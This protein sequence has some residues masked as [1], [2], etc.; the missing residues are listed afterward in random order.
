M[1]KREYI[2]VGHVI[3]ITLMFAVAKG[4]HDIRM[5]YNGT[6]SGL[7]DALWA[8]H[9][10]LP[11]LD[12]TLRSLLPGYHQADL[13]VAEMF[14]CFNL[15]PD[16]RPYAGVDVTH[17][18]NHPK[19]REDWEQHRKRIWEC[20]WR[21]F[22]GMRDSP[23][24]SIQLMLVAK[25]LAY[26]DRLDSNNPFQWDRIELNLPGSETYDPSLPWVMKIRRDGKLGCEI[27]I[28]VDDGRV[29]GWCKL[30]CWRAVQKFSRVLTT[31]GIQDASRKRTSPST[32]PG[33]WAGGVTSTEYGKDDG[34]PRGD[35]VK[36]V[37]QIKWEKI[38]SLVRELREM[39]TQDSKK[40]NRKRLEQIRGFLV[41]VARTFK[42]M[43]PYIKGLHLTIDGWREDRD[44]EGYRVRSNVAEIRQ[45]EKD[46]EQGI[47]VDLGVFILEE[48]TGDKE[49]PEEV[50]AVPRLEHDIET[51][52]EFTRGEAPAVEKVRVR[53]ALLALYLMGD[54][55][56]DGFGSSWWDGERLEYEAGTWKRQYGKLSSNF[57]EA[58]NLTA[59]AEEMGNR[60]LLS[61]REIFIFTDNSTYEGTFYKGHSKTS[62]AL[63]DLVRRL[64]MLE[65]K[66]GAIIHV[67]HIAGTRMKS[68][69]VDGL[70]RGDLVEGIMKGSNPWAAIPIN[71]DANF[72]TN[73]R[74]ETWIRS[75]WNDKYQTPWF[76]KKGD[77]STHY[78]SE[79]LK[80]LEPTDWFNLFNIKEHRLWIPPPAAMETV[81]EIFNEDRLVYPH[82]THVFAIPR[83]M[84]HLWRKQLFKDA[85]L[86]FYVRPG[87]P[88]WPRSMHEP[89]T[90][91][92][93]FPIA[94]VHNYRGPW[95]VKQLPGSKEFGE[96]LDSEFGDPRQ[97]GREEFLD[98]GS[99][100]PSL[101]ED[102]HRWTRD[103]LFEFLR[104]QR[105]FPPVQSGLLRC[106][107]PALRGG[108]V[109]NSKIVGRRRGRQRVRDRG[110]GNRSLHVR[111][112]GR[113]SNE[114]SF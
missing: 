58:C 71:E 49:A 74:V 109:P 83:L 77:R 69:G 33:P 79:E 114:S 8:P 34:N 85:D 44:E 96:R 100:M 31:L 97:V 55:S 104:Q 64:R 32:T 46:L 93:V 10:G 39:F 12:H 103:L 1:R 16:M 59:K 9:F 112:R 89:L 35:V 57:R 48:E 25:F 38:Q 3:S 20:W 92:V 13:D 18:Q 21:N 84:T 91:V 70:S 43:N 15:H 73:G 24:R 36:T 65:R 102:E 52:E 11:L 54:A 99:P 62:A 30:E 81:I 61:D 105:S 75:W 14:L 50:S 41:Y 88:F 82:L 22:M 23:Y 56:G 17:V 63:T 45:A 78:E 72:R 37:T 87:A 110:G 86:R 51:M 106:L 67:I 111:E 80:L 60:G 28:Y 113:P 94:H 19:N 90:I 4:A 68:A 101:W 95:T 47:E 27:Y 40:M 7:N 5:V 29:T 26:G 107:L 98:L 42:F 108:S 76:G 66:H 2:N 6:S 53:V